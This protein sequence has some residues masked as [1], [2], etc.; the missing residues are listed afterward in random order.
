MEN[1]TEAQQVFD[2]VLGLNYGEVI[3]LT[4]PL[5]TAADSFR[6]ALY[7]ERKVW[8]KKTLS[9]DQITITRNYSSFPFVLLVSKVPGV[10]GAVIKKQDGSTKKF[11]FKEKVEDFVFTP[12]PVVEKSELER[13]KE[14][15][16]DDGMAEEE[17]ED[18][19]KED[20]E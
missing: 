2:T 9:K 18:Y 7:R 1:K 17:I 20:K 16:R 6:S 10:M 11:T 3:E 4:F 5:D 12:E 15:M 19:F 8:A 14:L 13:Q